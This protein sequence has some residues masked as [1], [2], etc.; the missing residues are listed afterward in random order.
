MEKREIFKIVTL[1][2]IQEEFQLPK[3][4]C[5][6]YC[7]GDNQSVYLLLSRQP[8]KT[9]Y[10]AKMYLKQKEY[11]VA[12]MKMDWEKQLV[13]EKHLYPVGNLPYELD[14]LTIQENCIILEGTKEEILKE[15][16]VY[17][18][19]E[20]MIIKKYSME[21]EEDFGD[22]QEEKEK[23]V[24]LLV[25]KEGAVMKKQEFEKKIFDCLDSIKEQN[26]MEEEDRVVSELG[27]KVMILVDNCKWVR[28]WECTYD[29]NKN[30]TNAEIV[31]HMEYNGKNVKNASKKVYGSKIL[32]W[33][34]EE[35]LGGY[36]FREN[37]KMEICQQEDKREVFPIVD[38]EELKKQ[39]HLEVYYIY[40]YYVAYDQKI[41]ML[42][43]DIQSKAHG[44]K[45][46]KTEEKRKYV[47][48]V[49]EMD[50]EKEKVMGTEVYSLGVQNYNF[51]QVRP[52]KE[53]FLLLGWSLK[54]KYSK[55]S[56]VLLSKNGEIL[57][58]YYLGEGIG[59]CCTTKDGIIYTG[60][61]YYGVY[62]MDDE[63]WDMGINVWNGEGEKITSL[64]GDFCE[65]ANL[66]D[67]GMFWYFDGYNRLMGRDL[68]NKVSVLLDDYIY[69]MAVS[70]ECDKF[71]FE[72]GNQDFE[73]YYEYEYDEKE[74]KFWN[75][76]HISFVYENRKLKSEK[77][78]FCG[79]KMLFQEN[80]K[81]FGYYY[82]RKD[83]GVV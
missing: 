63:K 58:K 15:E 11:Y 72:C 50:W 79:S 8:Q 36:F 73:L 57:H 48:V 44:G 41:Y 3:L 82:R 70:K 56:G 53:K 12:E 24:E 2:E 47:V 22:L 31:I 52:L 10:P 83:S 23:R 80:E 49:M 17:E 55:E 14:T 54:E 32:F 61:N 30:I 76:K 67:N 26:S 4:F 6:D 45:K 29:T 71:I 33:V 13:T 16:V 75:E 74:K 46:Q 66:A 5:F 37:K 77:Y 38:L 19:N 43:C 34:D 78:V 27:E 81:L 42:F 18:G 20:L 35:T 1:K 7:V 68:E 65:T 64:E 39:Y 21:M 69:G 60:C 28:Y 9:E 25:S 62:D 51:Y 40:D 59:K